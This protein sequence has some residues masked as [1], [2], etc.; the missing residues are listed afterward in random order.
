MFDLRG[1]LK[2]IPEIKPG[3]DLNWVLWA[4]VDPIGFLNEF[5]NSLVFLH[6][7]DQ[8]KN[9]QWPESLEEGD[10]DFKEITF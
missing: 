6:I 3:P 1:T 4:G 8:L 5:K 7:R 9:G 2:R 10:T